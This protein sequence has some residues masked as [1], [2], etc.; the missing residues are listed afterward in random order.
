M[1]EIVRH[2]Y[3]Q[4]IDLLADA[5]YKSNWLSIS[6]KNLVQIRFKNFQIFPNSEAQKHNPFSEG[7]S[8]NIPP[9]ACIDV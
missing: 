1:A 2:E 8:L 6:Y 7:D 9:K 3:A 4:Q 5:V